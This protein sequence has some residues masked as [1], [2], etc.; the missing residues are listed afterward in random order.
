MSTNFKIGGK[1]NWKGQPERLVYMGRN[2]SGNGYWNQ[3]AKVEYPTIV[4]CEVL[5]ADLKHFEETQ[6][7]TVVPVAEIVTF[8]G[9]DG[10][11]EVSWSKG[12]MPPVGTKLYAHP[13]APAES[14]W[15]WVPV[16]P[17]P[18][19]LHAMWQDREDFRGQ[20]ENKTARHHYALLLKAAPSAA[21]PGGE[22]TSA[23]PASVQH[24]ATQ[25]PADRTSP[26]QQE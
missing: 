15:Q 3:F 21:Q 9:L 14:G 7:A 17:T 8:G 5:D 23:S 4:W 2:W 24:G 12:K 25:S 1:Y 22:A 26:T 18:A 20:S 6:P 19:M 10:Q 13:S 11:K 16:E